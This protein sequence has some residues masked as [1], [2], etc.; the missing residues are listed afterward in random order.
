MKMII[1]VACFEMIYYYDLMQ[2]RSRYSK[3]ITTLDNIHRVQSRLK[4]FLLK[5]QGN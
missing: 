4:P 2:P 3:R 5:V 1:K